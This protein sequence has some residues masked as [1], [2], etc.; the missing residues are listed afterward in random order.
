MTDRADAIP[1]APS[2]LALS[3]ASRNL[4]HGLSPRQ[5]AY[6]RALATGRAIK[7]VAYEFG[8][9]EGTV[10]NTL[11]VTYTRL[12]VR[13]KVEAFVQMGWIVVPEDAS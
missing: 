10:K 13:G 9:A 6:L 3:G 5:Y 2:R 12:G 7:E 11:V 1:A 8:V 4:R